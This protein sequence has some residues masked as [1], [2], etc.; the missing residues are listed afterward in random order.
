MAETNRIEYKQ[1]LTDS[2]E[3]EVNKQ[4]LDKIDLENKTITLITAKE[5]KE[6]RFWNP[7]ALR[8]AVINAFVHNDYTSEVPPKFEIFDDRIEITSTC[9]LPDELSLEEFFEGFS[10]PRNKEIMRIYK[11][12][13]LV[14]QLG[15]GIP[16]ILESYDKQCFKFSDHFLRMSFPI[17]KE[18]DDS[19]INYVPIGATIG[20]AIGGAIL[21]LTDRQE[22]VLAIIKADQTIS[23]R[24]I[25]EQLK[26]NESAVLKH[27]D[28]LKEKGYL[29]RIGGTRGYW[30]IMKK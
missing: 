11:D 12:L 19:V 22:E 23:Y 9:S 21:N 8:E 6:T 20:G 17:N 10:V 18:T 16:R 27:I 26:I 30:Q 14:E 4:V 7:I 25:A 5:R 15:S 29:T 2:L 24:A 1:E 28:L 3:K 13:D